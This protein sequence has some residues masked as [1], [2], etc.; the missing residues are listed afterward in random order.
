M[1]KVFIIDDSATTRNALIRGLSGN[2][3]VEIVGI[4]NSIEPAEENLEK[5]APDVIILDIEIPQMDGIEFLRR[6]R[7]KNS[8]AILALTSQTQRGR[9]ATM[10]ALESGAVDFIHFPAT[11]T[12]REI[13]L[14][15]PEIIEKI[16]IASQ[17][18]L[19]APISEN[20]KSKLAQFSSTDLSLLSKRTDCVIAIGASNGGPEAIREIVEKLPAGTPGVVIVQHM[21]IGFTKTFADRLN[22]VSLMRVKEADNGDMIE[23]GKILIAPGDYHIIVQPAKGGYKVE[24]QQSE[25]IHGQRPAYDVLCYSIAE[26]VKSKAC[27]VILTGWSKDGAEGLRALHHSG[28]KT[29]AQDIRTC[30]YGEMPRAALDLGAVDTVLPLN[31]IAS[32]II[33]YIINDD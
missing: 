21:P 26:H 5:L 23:N 24:L 27:G 12:L 25:K 16:I 15:M 6:V 18:N 14:L 9:Y 22:E 4:F 11:D 32:E 13:E 17:A 30:V 2:K 1:I 10:M 29:I 28:A 19:S 33:H 20:H 8:T 31:E 7:K 3:I